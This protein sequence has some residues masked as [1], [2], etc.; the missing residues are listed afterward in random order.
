MLR[1][2]PGAYT[3]F[4]RKSDFESETTAMMINKVLLALF[5]LSGIAI[6]GGSNTDL[7][8]VPPTFIRNNGQWDRS[9]RYAML[10]GS[11]ALWFLDD[12]LVITRPRTGLDLPLEYPNAGEGTQSA[13]IEVIHLRYR[14][15]STRLQLRATDTAM[16]VS[17]FY[18]GADSASWREQVSNHHGLRYENVWEGVDI[19][20]DVRSG[21]AEEGWMEIVP[22]GAACPSV[23]IRDR[24]TASTARGGYEITRNAVSTVSLYDSL[25]LATFMSFI[26]PGGG[27]LAK[28]DDRYV[29]MLGHAP[30]NFPLH[31]AWHSPTVPDQSY[32]YA[33][34]YD[35]AIRNVVYS[36]YFGPA[37]SSKVFDVRGESVNVFCGA[38]LGFPVNRS[39]PGSIPP[40]GPNDD[41]SAIFVLDAS[42]RMEVSSFIGG[43]G[44]IVPQSLH[45]RGK[46]LYLLG[47]V[48]KDSIAAIT[49]DAIERTAYFGPGRSLL[50][51]V[52][53]VNLDSTK[54]LSYLCP[55]RE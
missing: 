47:I 46:E 2:V 16:A 43:P 23:R 44:E 35:P 22:A 36:T 33:V 37:I 32:V 17:H 19:E 7:D 12:G 38:Q 48:E 29:Y 3:G 55:L 39:L 30:A 51:G 8:H 20:F 45:R 31:G 27:H 1:A 54:Y 13:G 6:A 24:R 53:S 14:N 34:K 52:V 49:K 9:V 11:S 42:G 50:F 26:G 18:L 4:L 25:P 28:S 40:T 41:K 5:M 15:A 10:N 21:Q